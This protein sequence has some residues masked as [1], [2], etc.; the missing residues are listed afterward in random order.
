VTS[1]AVF[2]EGAQGRGVTARCAWQ[3]GGGTKTVT[4]EEKEKEEEERVGPG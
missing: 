2:V 3:P 1:H 4:K